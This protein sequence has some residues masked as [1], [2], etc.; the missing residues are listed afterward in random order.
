[1]QRKTKDKTTSLPFTISTIL[2]C[3]CEQKASYLHYYEQFVH[4]GLLMKYVRAHSRC[5]STPK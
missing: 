1:M 4:G 5:C 3:D 2:F